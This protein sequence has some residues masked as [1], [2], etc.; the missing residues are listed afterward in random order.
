MVWCI[1]TCFDVTKNSSV[2]CYRQQWIH[3]GIHSYIANGI[4]LKN[5]VMT[6]RQ[7][8]SQV[9]VKMANNEK[10]VNIKQCVLTLKPNEL[11]LLSRKDS[12]TVTDVFE[13][14]Y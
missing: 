9:L 13:K 14:N 6:R 11:Q 1:N 2:K 4:P 12:A 5:A 7:M 10:Y 8:R 3:T